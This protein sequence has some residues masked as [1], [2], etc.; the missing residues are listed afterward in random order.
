MGTPEL[1]LLAAV[2]IAI[3]VE[4][5]PPAF[6]T[7][8]RVGRGGCLS[9]PYRFTSMIEKA[10]AQTGAVWAG[11]DDPRITSKASWDSDQERR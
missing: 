2:I 6:C 4:D 8:A 1:G 7:Q 9:R 11:K 5:G 10:E 3:Y